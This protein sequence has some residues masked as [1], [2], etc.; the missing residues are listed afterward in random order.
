MAVSL[1]SCLSKK[2]VYYF[3]GIEKADTTKV[4]NYEVI[5]KPDDILNIVVSSSNYTAVEAVAPFNQ[6][7]TTSSAEV[8]NYLVDSNGMV[9][10]PILGEIKA[11]GSTKLKFEQQLKEK[12]KEYLPD[13][14][15]NVKIVNFKFTIL[16]DVKNPGVYPL[17]SERVSILDGIAASGDLLI[18]GNRKEV[19]LIRDVDGVKSH[20]AIDLTDPSLVYSDKFYLQQN[21][22]VYIRQNKLKVLA[23]GIPAGITVGVSVLSIVVTIFA[24]ITR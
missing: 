7:T 11:A 24:I 18:S 22:V 23:G 16:G 20:Y 14:I 5:I 13:P 12:L 3:Q 9:K 2:D 17:A 15:V 21:D 10:L 6:V 8:I 1:S 19:V 4:V